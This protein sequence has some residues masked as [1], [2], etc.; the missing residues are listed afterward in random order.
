M[1][2]LL[3]KCI[4]AS[5]VCLIGMLNCFEK[6]VV[7]DNLELLSS[8]T[9]FSDELFFAYPKYIA[10]TGVSLVITDLNDSKIVE[11]DYSGKLIRTYGQKGRGPGEY[12]MPSNPIM[13]NDLLYISDAGNAK[14]LTFES[15]GS[16]N[17]EIKIS[18]PILEFTTNGEYLYAFTF[19][20]VDD[21][22]IK[23]YSMN[24]EF[25][26][27]FGK[28]ETTEETSLNNITKLVIYNNE[29]WVL[30]LYFPIL[31]IYSLDGELI[32]KYNLSNAFDYSERFNQSKEKPKYSNVSGQK[33][34]YQS[35]T[36]N[37]DGI[38][39]GIYDPS[40]NN[41]IAD[42]FNFD[43]IPITR[44]RYTSNDEKIYHFHSV[45][46]DSTLYV[47]GADTEPGLFIFNK[48]D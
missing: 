44:Y 4:V 16:F 22:L 42:H 36:M 33:V 12:L 13:A 23:K 35:I 47:A 7:K 18:D 48:T 32:Q 15:N 9:E 24:G 30:H 26:N 34:I 25:I 10:D 31:K 6:E 2:H 8:T 29:L 3:I 46:V 39:L 5:V 27:S 11:V 20:S 19:N 28:L 38:Y 40:N 41:I 43:V 37:K 1:K 45:L 17:N 14:I 21:R